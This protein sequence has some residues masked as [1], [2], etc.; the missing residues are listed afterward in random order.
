MDSEY[1]YIEK[2]TAY[3]LSELL[4]VWGK[5]GFT[6]ET[7]SIAANIPL[8][9]LENLQNNNNNISEWK[10]A[11]QLRFANTIMNTAKAHK[12]LHSG[13]EGLYIWGI[14][15]SF[16]EYFKIDLHTLADYISIK[17]E[18]LVDSLQNFST[19]PLEKRH[20]ISVSLMRLF[21]A[22]TQKTYDPQEHM[23]N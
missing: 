11:D 20:F 16:A 14:Y 3:H 4:T 22:L 6:L 10:I 18:D 5:M 17:S 21:T 12:E 15:E 7:L 1:S 23:E 2:S 8:K 19:L 9:I 13:D